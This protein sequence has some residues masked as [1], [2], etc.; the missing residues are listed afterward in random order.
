MKESCFKG[1][2][3]TETFVTGPLYPIHNQHKFYCQICK[4]NVSIRSKGA[5]EIIRHYQSETHLRKDQRWRFERLSVTDKVTGITRHQVRGK[6]GHILTPLEVER[7]KPLFENA[8]LV[9]VGEKYPFY[10]EYMANSESQQTA[11]DQRASTQV[12]LVGS[13]VPYD[14]N[15]SLL[16]ALWSRVGE[17]MNFREQFSPFDL[18]SATMTV[19]LFLLVTRVRFHCFY[20]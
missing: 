3:W 15:I 10:D 6:H 1:I 12:D 19:S 20:N 18:S 8:P 4:S 16:Q 2:K 9:D 13:F 17:Y 5:Q 7:E 14:G 11:E